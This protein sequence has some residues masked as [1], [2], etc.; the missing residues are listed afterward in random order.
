VPKTQDL[1][2]FLR[3]EH[4]VGVLLVAQMGGAPEELQLI[5]QTATFDPE[6]QGLRERTAYIVRALGVKEHRVS[7]G[8]FNDLFIASEH[9]I[10]LHHNA[11]VHEIAFTGAP[12]DPNELVLDI[13]AAYSATFGPWRDIAEDINRTQPLFDLLQ[14]G[15]GVLG[16]MPKPGA[17][18]MTR[19]FEH[20]GMSSSL[21]QVEAERS[22]DDDGKMAQ[23]E[24]DLK[25]MGLGD[26]YFVAMAFVVDEMNQKLK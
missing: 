24:T 11:S 9:P 4:N 15:E 23:F 6:I 21:T 14:S 13:Q 26:S 8:V 25:I 22:A 7:L 1:V 20:H 3:G 2:T 10:L 18:R 17:E 16:R 12:N 19:V 5:I